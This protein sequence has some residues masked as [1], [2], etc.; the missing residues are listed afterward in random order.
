MC[1]FC[2]GGSD[3]WWACV[4]RSVEHESR[5]NP[6]PPLTDEQVVELRRLFAPAIAAWQKERR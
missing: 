3:P 5:A 1:Q 6:M 4:H 2:D